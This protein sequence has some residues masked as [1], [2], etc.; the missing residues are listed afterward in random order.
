MPVKVEHNGV[1]IRGTMF[2]PKGQAPFPG[3]IDLFGGHGGC[4]ET[5]AALLAKHVRNEFQFILSA[6]KYFNN[7]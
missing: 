7:I 5:R 3:I 6:E 2:I 4:V 1:K